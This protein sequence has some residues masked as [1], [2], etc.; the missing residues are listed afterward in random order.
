M[1]VLAE[2]VRGECSGRSS[3]GNK[4]FFFLLINLSHLIGEKM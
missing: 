4:F 1:S 3:N 2:F